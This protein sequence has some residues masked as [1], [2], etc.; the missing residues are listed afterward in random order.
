M[1]L[2]VAELEALFAAGVSHDTILALAR[3]RATD[4][5]E[6]AREKLEAEREEQRTTRSQAKLRKRLQRERDAITSSASTDDAY[7]TGPLPPRAVTSDPPPTV[8]LV[9]AVTSDTP[10][11]QTP[12][13]QKERGVGGGAREADLISDQ[14]RALAAQVMDIIGINRTAIPPGWQTAPRFMQQG[15]DGGWRAETVLLAA[16]T[17][18]A[19]IAQRG[20]ELP[21]SV[22]Y[23][24]RPI[25]REHTNPQRPLPMVGVVAGNTEG[26]RG[27]ASSFG[28]SYGAAKDRARAAHAKLKAAIA[29]H[30]SGESDGPASWLLP[31]TRRG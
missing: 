12:Y 3:V 29:D 5:K 8:T 30:D 4:E 23:L 27:S 20:G 18:K 11:P 21:Y 26:T 13:P 19:Q 17:V 6:R 2:S 9:T 14:A 10:F 22:G 28:G 15:L 1:P 25:N 31:A 16:Q 24:S 7:A